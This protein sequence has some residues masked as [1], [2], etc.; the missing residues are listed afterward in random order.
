MATAASLREMMD[1][2]LGTMQRVAGD[3]RPGIVVGEVGTVRRINHGVAMVEGLPGVRAEELVRFPHGDLGLT[4]NL[5]PEEVGV[6]LLNRVE[7]VGAGAEVHR[8]G[9]VLDFPVGPALIG[10]V[11]NAGG[12]PLDDRGPI[13]AAERRQV[14]QPAP[15]L[16]ERAPVNVPLQTGIKVVDALFPIGRGQ[17]ELIVGDRQTGKTALAL[18]T[19]LNQRGTGVLC[20]YCAIG[21]RAVSVRRIVAEL[22]RS[23]ALRH[24]AVVAAGSEDPPGSLYIAPFAA[25]TLAEYFADQGRD[26]LVVHDDLTNHARAYRELSLLLRRPPARE[27]YPGDV[28]YLHARLL[29]RATQRRAGGSV[30]ALPIIESQAE[31]LSAYIPTNLISITDG[32]LYLSPPLFRRGQTPAVDIG[33]SVS[34]VGGKAQLPAYRAVAG[35]L[36]LAYAQFE[37]LE[38]FARFG[39]R[40][41]E[42]TRHTLERGRRVREV[43]R[44]AEL[45][46]VPVGEQIPV[47]LAASTGLMDDVPLA[48]V[49]AAERHIRHEV[50]RQCGALSERLEAGQPLGDRD[51]ETLLRVAGDAI[52]MAHGNP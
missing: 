29:E 11:V 49:G 34:R 4:L 30:T 10:R 5:D 23:G 51:R 48:L 14:E 24:T 28:F 7:G 25:M 1:R 39:T 9:R 45:E 20:I 6:V 3:S 22:R 18:T 15:T 52:G 42:R 12:L 17:R 13:R 32:Q 46:T 8:T 44:Q 31:T 36:R 40:L 33:L 47:L 35:S 21:Q 43:L 16:T 50:R 37:E 41:D 2:A 27:A 38:S 26:V 19:I